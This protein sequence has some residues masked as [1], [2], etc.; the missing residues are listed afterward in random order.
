MVAACLAVAATPGTLTLI[1]SVR[2]GK[3][4]AMNPGEP[5]DTD[6]V[7]LPSAHAA[8]ET[9]ERLKAL[10]A[11]KGIEV[12][13]HIDHAAG[14]EKVGLPLRPTQVLVFGNPK[15][16]TPLMQSRQAIGLDLPLRVLVWQDE[17]GKVWLTYRRVADLARRHYVTGHDEAV[18]ALDDGLAG[19][20]RAATA[21]E[22]GR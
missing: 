4:Q 3:E 20:A 1:Q 8:T 5:A 15:A 18:K 17:S 19:L 2:G 14:A 9:V 21:K 11:Q 13:A 12:F 22:S 7:T 16:G 10:L 6:L